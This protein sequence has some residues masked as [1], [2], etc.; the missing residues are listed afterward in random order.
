[1]PHDEQPLPQA[2][3]RAWKTYPTACMP[4][5][6]VRLAISPPEQGRGV[7]NPYLLI[8]PPPQLYQCH[9]RMEGLP[10]QACDP[11]AMA[12]EDPAHLLP[13]AWVPQENLKEKAY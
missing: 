10:T 13:C 1:M 3:T 6:S 11:L 9:L 4:L 7:L 8:P 12:G 5:L 2:A